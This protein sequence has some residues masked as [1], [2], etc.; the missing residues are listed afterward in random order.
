MWTNSELLNWSDILK[1]DG[2]PNTTSNV[3]R[4]SICRRKWTTGLWNVTQC[5]LVQ[6]C[7][8]FD[9]SYSIF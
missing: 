7:S 4:N 6:I 9:R 2:N 5:S 8:R 1:Y 3:N